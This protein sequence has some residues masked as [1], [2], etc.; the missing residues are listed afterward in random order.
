M[1]KKDFA[2]VHIHTPHVIIV[3]VAVDQT[4]IDEKTTAWKDAQK[5]NYPELEE[6]DEPESY[7]QCRAPELCWY[8]YRY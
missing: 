7:R 2:H 5:Y 1:D 3:P 8:I 6:T 4:D